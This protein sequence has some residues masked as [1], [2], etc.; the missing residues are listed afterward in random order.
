MES[1]ALFINGHLGMRVL[2][3]FMDRTDTNIKLVILNHPKKRSESFREEVETI[4]SRSESKPLIFEWNIHALDELLVSLA[5]CSFG[6]SALFGHIIPEKIANYLR[7]GIANLHPSLLPLGRGAD[8]VPWGIIE[9]DK[10]GA[11]IHLISKDLDAGAILSQ[12]EIQ[13]DLGMNAGKIYELCINSLF[14]QLV[15][16]INP[17][18]EGNLAPRAQLTCEARTR[19]STE[20]NSMRTIDASEISSFSS[21]VRR[22]QALTY[23]DGRAPRFRD[24]L[25][26]LWNIDFRLTKIEEI[27]GENSEQ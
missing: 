18:L 7:H 15:Q 17:W 25:G 19:K 9:R 11:T 24:E 22:M 12:E 10:Q 26:T 6:I 14:D 2:T 1:G 13:V 16:V 5:K 23:S 20:L 27:R 3:H 8:P 4:L 21:F